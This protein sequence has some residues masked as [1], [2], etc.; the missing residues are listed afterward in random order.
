MLQVVLPGVGGG[1]PLGGGVVWE[2]QASSASVRVSFGAAP[3]GPGG[4]PVGERSTRP[5]LVVLAVVAARICEDVIEQGEG[6]TPRTHPNEHGTGRR[7]VVNIREQ[8]GAAAD[9]KAEKD[10]DR[11]ADGQQRRR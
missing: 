10:G 6:T 5:S 11:G 7:A 4:T 9:H 8:S 3:A 2:R 1:Q